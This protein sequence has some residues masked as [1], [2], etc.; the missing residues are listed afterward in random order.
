MIALDI[1]KKLWERKVLIAFFVAVAILFCYFGLFVC[2][3]QTA[4][5]YIKYTDSSAVDGVTASGQKLDPYEITQP[6]IIIK[7]LEQLGINAKNVNSF[8]QRISVTPVI[9]SAEQEKYASWLNN[10][11]DYANTEEGKDTPIYYRI[12]F[13]TN[14]G[15]Q[16]GRSFLSALINQYR[17]YYTEKYVGF[18]EVAPIPESVILNSDYFQAVDKLKSHVEETKKY[19]NNIA[20]NVVDYR[21]S[22]TGYSLNDLIDSFGLFLETE[23]APVTQY[24]LDTGVSKDVATL[25]AALKQSADT[26]QRESDEQALKASTQKYMM[27]VYAEKNKDYVSTVISPENYDTQ[28][29]ADVERDKA[30]LR[31]MTTYD[32]LILDYVDYAVKSSDLLID[33]AYINANLSKFGDTTTTVGAPIA[34]IASLYERYASLMELTEQTLSSCNEY[35]SAKALMQ[36]SGVKVTESLPELLYYTISVLLAFCLGCGYV[37]TSEFLKFNGIN[38]KKIS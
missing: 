31:E 25:V 24:I 12:D 13:I 11:E 15:I 23:I 1:F 6:Y 14:E 28:V 8:A 5:V 36:A 32:Q 33:K 16:F 34:E 7:A 3:S 29:R 9:S 17:V 35:N 22:L 37:I 20:N 10:F 21:S 19:L 26:A 30:Y 4:T 2:Q 18:Y 38:T 27:S